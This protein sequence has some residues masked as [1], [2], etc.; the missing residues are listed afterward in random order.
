MNETRKLVPDTIAAP[1]VGLRPSTFRK[2]RCTGGGP[3]FY[4]LNGRTIRY[5]V[6]ECRLWA[7]QH[8]HNSTA[9]YPET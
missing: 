6:D 9:E 1:A 8:K 4:R 7:S 2:F 5:D 3:P